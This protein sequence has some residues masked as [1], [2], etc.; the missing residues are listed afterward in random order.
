M[1]IKDQ[2]QAYNLQEEF[3]SRA[4]KAVE[5]L[6]ESK[7]L[8]V[9]ALVKDVKERIA[10]AKARLENASKDREEVVQRMD[11]R[12]ARLSDDVKRLEAGLDEFHK[13][14]AQED[15]KPRRRRPKKP[16]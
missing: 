2:D 3:L 9:N 5:M 7:S 15:S 12:I 8:P 10:V 4:M 1:P 16:S 6:R 11:E 14:S 13:R